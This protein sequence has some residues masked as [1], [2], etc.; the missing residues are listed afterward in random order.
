MIDPNPVAT[1]SAIMNPAAP[2][3]AQAAKDRMEV[4]HQDPA[5]MQRVAARDP[6]AF[7]EHEKLWRVSRGMTAE[8]QPPVNTGDV[9]QQMSE[10]GVREAEMR[11]QVLRREGLNDQQ[12]YEVLNERPQ[13]AEAKRLHDEEY[14]RLKADEG[15][16]TRLRAR[17]REAR[18][19][20]ARHLY[21]G[22]CR[23]ER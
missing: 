1:P 9:F 6:E 19:E 21:G 4:L 16:Q 18:Y 22:A 20:W 15:F 8:P 2:A 11:A 12:V 14:E 7:K 3:D 5:F 23:S 13:S 17:D 10:R